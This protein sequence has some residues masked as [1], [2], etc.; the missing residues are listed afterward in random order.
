MF[1]E[2]QK[3][4]GIA[5][6]PDYSIW[7]SASAGSGKTTVL[8]KRLL[9]M[10]LAGIKPSKILCI[11]FTNTG[12]AEMRNRINAKLA[13]WATLNDDQLEK[14]IFELEEGNRNGISEKLNIA[15]SL[16]AK[17]L[18]CSNDFKILTIHSFCQQIIK[19]FPLEA[20]IIPNFKIADEILSTELLLKAKDEILKVKYEEIKEAIKYVFT[21]RNEEDFLKLLKQTINQKDNLLYLKSRFFSIDGVIGEIRRVFNIGIDENIDSITKEFIKNINLSLLTADVINT[22]KDIGKKTDLEF[23]NSI[24]SAKNNLNKYINLFLTKNKNTIRKTIITKGILDKFL[25]LSNFITDEAE[26]VF[27]FKEKL[28]N[29]YN[30]EFTTAFLRITYCVFDIYAKLKRESGYLDYSDLI[31]ETSRL[32]NDSK[33]R[34]L[35]NENIYSS[36]INYKLDEGLDHLL[37]DEAQDTSPIQWDIVKSIT[38]EFFA[39]YGQKGDENRTI[40]VVGDEK[41]SIFSFQGAEPANFNIML[42]YYREKIESSGKKFE[43]IYLETSFRS[44]KSVLNIAD[45]VFSEPSRKIAITKL[46]N[47]IKHNIVRND[48]VGKVEIWPLIEIKNDSEKK[49]KE[50][51][52]LG[53]WEINYLENIELTNKQKLAEVIA[54]QIDSW[55]KNGKVIYSRKDKCLRKIKYSDIMILVKNRDND[56][57]NYLIRQFNKH[58]IRS[59]GNDKFNLTENIIS[60]D[61]ISL[62][63]FILFNEDDLNLANIIKS[64]FLSLNEND[65]YDLCNFKNTNDCSLWESLKSIEKFNK[66]KNILE[67]F[68]IKNK[69]MELYELIFYIF[70]TRGFRIRFKERFPYVADEVINEFLSIANA[71]ESNH[72][73]STLLNFI[74]FLENS[75]LEIKRDMEQSTDEIRV[76]TIHSSKGLESPIVIMPDTNHATNTIYKIDKVLNFKEEG[77]DYTI[78]LLQKESSF[79]LDEV[80]DKMKFETEE[81]YLRLLYVAITRAENELYVCDCARRSETNENSWYEILKQAVENSGAKK[82]RSDN[83]DGDILYVG[84]DDSFDLNN[85]ACDKIKE[86]NF[87][88]LNTIEDILCNISKNKEKASEVKIINPSTYYAENSLKNPHE[89]SENIEKGKLVH[90][91]LEILPDSPRGE[92]NDIINIYLKNKDNIEEIKSITL[93]VLNNREFDFLFSKNSKAEVPVFGNIDGNIISGQIDRLLIVDDIVYIVDYKNTNYLPNTTPKRYI[94]QLELYK[95]LL[96]KIYINKI[97]KVYILWTSFGKI[98]EIILN[99]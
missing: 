49:N 74:H 60:K 80:K 32:L 38:E 98:E 25:E 57:I 52:S 82:K 62:F 54:E 2:V 8:V 70:E 20:N 41:Q 65:L 33:Y 76:M 37:I 11:T 9:R 22:I 95:K 96:E 26:R 51:N 23:I 81:E 63:K 68:L 50:K 34:N 53:D 14:E 13:E 21:Y 59:M 97:V 48:G 16:F 73:N 4:Q 93:K 85:K 92:W 75:N 7:T 43:K 19:R 40:F 90:K 71:Y 18:D 86:D 6:N 61:I 45:V 64:P 10:F 47:T 84:D 87:L 67:D 44:L 72:N 94:K 91:L 24:T 30:F 42:N 69:F 58:N 27:E 5:S 77:N 28:S 39:G 3:K 15:R 83:I 55:F 99:A 36:W 79:F 66:E 46:Q 1:E 56:F 29:I 17:I 31:F 89:N 88:N 78:P 35:G 12:A